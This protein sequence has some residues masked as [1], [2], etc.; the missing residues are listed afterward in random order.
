MY[1]ILF[2]LAIIVTTVNSGCTNAGDKKKQEI[3]PEKHDSTHKERKETDTL[4]M[5]MGGNELDSKKK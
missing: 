2:L 4:G 1:K 5:K 3:Q